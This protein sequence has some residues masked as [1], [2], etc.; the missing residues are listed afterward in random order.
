MAYP[1]SSY[2]FGSMFREKD[3]GNL[4]QMIFMCDDYLRYR[5]IE[6]VADGHFGHVAPIAYLSLW[7]IYCTC[8]FLV[9]TRKGIS[10]LDVLS[11]AKLSKEEHKELVSTITVE[12]Q[13]Q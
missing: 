3:M 1:G 6:L 11:N 9:G 10:N 5:N 7:Q 2:N 13:K 8:A 4:F 12:S